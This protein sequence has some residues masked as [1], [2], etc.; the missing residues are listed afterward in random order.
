MNKIKETSKHLVE[1]IT[2][3]IQEKKGVGIVIADLSHIEG[4]IADYFVICSGNSPAQIEAI[5]ESVG[6]LVRNKH[7]NEKPVYV[8]GLGNDQWVAIDY[9][10]VLVHIFQPEVREFYDLEDLWEDAKI[11]KVPDLD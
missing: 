7:N 4:S 11:T 10:D 5:T 9:V 8:S 3:G 6:N 2:E 1:T